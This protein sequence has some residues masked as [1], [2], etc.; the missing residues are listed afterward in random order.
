MLDP[1]STKIVDHFHGRNRS[2]RED[3][4]REFS[5]VG[6]LSPLR[7][8]L[9]VTLFENAFAKVKLP[10]DSLPPCFDLKRVEITYS[11]HD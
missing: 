6:R 9:E 10:F 2:L 3:T 4:N 1:E 5:A 7:G 8:K 11:V